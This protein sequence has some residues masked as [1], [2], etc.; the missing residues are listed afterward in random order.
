M[1]FLGVVL[2]N[3]SWGSQGESIF[4]SV[5]TEG[6]RLVQSTSQPEHFGSRWNHDYA[7]DRPWEDH[8]KASGP[9]LVVS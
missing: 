4:F 6:V 2:V 7:A 1:E 9:I 3:S 8:G 5:N